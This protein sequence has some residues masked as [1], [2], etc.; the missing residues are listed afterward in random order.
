[1]ITDKK[2]VS[3]FSKDDAVKLLLSEGFRSALINGVVEIY[4]SEGE[5]FKEISRRASALL[6]A[7]GYNASWGLIYRSEDDAEIKA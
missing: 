5:D 7:A 2:S 3:T 1:M 6:R 4:Y